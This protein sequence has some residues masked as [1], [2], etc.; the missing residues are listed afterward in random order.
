MSPHDVEKTM[1]GHPN[2]QTGAWNINEKRRLRPKAFGSHGG[3]AGC[4]GGG[5]N[6]FI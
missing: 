2:P 6:G 1:S 3:G 5:G 4:G